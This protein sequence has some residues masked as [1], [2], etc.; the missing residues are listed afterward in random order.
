MASV[1]Q[2]ETPSPTGPILHTSQAAIKEQIG[3]SFSRHFQGANGTPFLSAPL[4]HCVGMDSSSS[5]ARAILEGSFV[6]PTEVD[7]YTRQF[8]STLSQP[9]NV[10]PPEPPSISASDFQTYWHCA[11]ECTSSSYSGLH[12]GHYKATAD[13]PTLSEIHA[14]FIQLCFTHS[15]SPQRWQSGLQVVLEKKAGVIHIDKLRALLLMEADFNFGN[16]MLF[17]YQ[18]MQ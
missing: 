9:P 2:V 13:C 15:F 1:S 18:M 3:A 4:L 8:I 7:E 11:R 10:P 14:I 16:K 6:C 5:A 12:F 17:G